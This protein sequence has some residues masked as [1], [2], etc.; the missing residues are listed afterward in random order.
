M[1]PISAMLMEM[2]AVRT[3]MPMNDFCSHAY[4]K[5]EQRPTISGTASGTDISS[6]N[7]GKLR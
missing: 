3:S 6:P 5:Q 7:F 1:L 4:C 2:V